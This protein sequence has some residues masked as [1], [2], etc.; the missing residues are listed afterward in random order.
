MLP[1]NLLPGRSKASKS[2]PATGPMEEKTV[3]VR[4]LP[5]LQSSL[6]SC[7]LSLPHWPEH[8]QVS[9]R[10]PY[11]T[12]VCHPMPLASKCFTKTQPHSLPCIGV[13][14][15]PSWSE[16]ELATK[17]Y[18]LWHLVDCTRVVPSWSLSDAGTASKRLKKKCVYMSVCV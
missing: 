3:C 10:F 14:D 12:K 8:T 17:S 4:P 1:G 13:C 2:H 6:E 7:I 9:E 5:G 11:S 15:A 16:T 18:S